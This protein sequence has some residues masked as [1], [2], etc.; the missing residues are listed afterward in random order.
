MLRVK[1]ESLKRGNERGAGKE[2]KNLTIDVK[3]IEKDNVGNYIR[4]K[5]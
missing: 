5:M 2:N 3:I 1:R 4:I